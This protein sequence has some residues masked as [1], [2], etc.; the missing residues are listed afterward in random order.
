MRFWNIGAEGQ[1]LVGGIATAAAMIYLA[2]QTA[3]GALLIVMFIVSIMPAQS[4]ASYPLLQGKVGQKRK[5]FLPDVEL[6][7]H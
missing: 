6:C 5:L 3:S 4:G 7:R 1:I 2:R